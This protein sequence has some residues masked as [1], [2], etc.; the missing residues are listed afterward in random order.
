VVGTHFCCEPTSEAKIPQLS[1]SKFP[2]LFS[3]RRNFLPGVAERTDRHPHLGVIQ[4]DDFGRRR[5][6]Q[7]TLILE[8]D[9]SHQFIQA[10]DLNEILSWIPSNKLGQSV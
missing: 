10:V 1:G 4:K 2:G 8:S 6:V 7:R 5:T 3:V 9:Y